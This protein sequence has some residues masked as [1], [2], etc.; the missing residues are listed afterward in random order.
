[1]RVKYSQYAKLKMAKP[2]I[3]S[4]TIHNTGTRESPHSQKPSHFSR[5]RNTDFSK[6]GTLQLFQDMLMDAEIADH[7][8]SII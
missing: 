7:E 2:H 6:Y 1:M 5:F 3:F 8:V 4:V